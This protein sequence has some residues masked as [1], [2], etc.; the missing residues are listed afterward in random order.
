MK[1]R[2]T[3]IAAALLL[4]GFTLDCANVPP[5]PGRVATSRE[6]LLANIQA[7]TPAPEITDQSEMLAEMR[8]GERDDAGTPPLGGGREPIH[9]SIDGD[10]ALDDPIESEVLA[11]TIAATEQFRANLPPML[12]PERRWQWP[13]EDYTYV[14]GLIPARN[15]RRA[16]R[17]VDLAAPRGTPIL[18]MA[19]GRVVR[20]GWGLTGYGRWVVIDHG[21]GFKSLYAHCSR[22]DVEVG[23]HVRAGQRIAAVGASGRSTGNHLHFEIR[24]NDQPIDP[25]SLLPR[26]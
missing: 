1:L 22:V 6:T 16:H 23:D 19:P 11:E 10:G 4:A 3:A 18:A 17:G 24:V 15:G 9:I 25:E 14:R 7:N 26:R 20:A 2:H 13:L 5:T 21:D 12:P 8:P